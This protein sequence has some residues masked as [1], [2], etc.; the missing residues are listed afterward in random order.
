MLYP[1]FIYTASACVSRLRLGKFAQ[2]TATGLATVLIDIP[3]DIMAVKFVHWTWHDTDPNIHDRH[4]WVP[5]TSYYFHATFAA[6]FTFMFHFWRRRMCEND[7]EN[8]W[9]SDKRISR[10]FLCTFLTAFCGMA[11]GVLQFL[12]LYHPLHDFFK[13]HTEN[14]VITLFIVY[15]LIA[16]TQD[17]NPTRGS[18]STTGTG[19]FNELAIGLILHYSLYLGM[20]IYGNPEDEVSVGLH[21]KLGPCDQWMEQKT[22]FTLVTGEVNKRRRYLCL[23][24]YDEK[25]FDFKCLSKPPQEYSE[26]YTICGM[27]FENRAEY[28]QVIV[29][30]CLT[31]FVFFRS[32]LFSSGAEWD[33]SA[34]AVKSKKNK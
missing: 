25:Y 14:C 31:A 9:V 32:M 5:W 26:W 30:I 18:R 3:Y 23:Q 20:A 19:G 24:D 13:I 16:W 1:T 21:E 33:T 34:K 2:A 22:L 12:P 7:P 8:Q 10:E 4:Y 11:G 28:I 29:L 27:P 17:R 15:F 6:S